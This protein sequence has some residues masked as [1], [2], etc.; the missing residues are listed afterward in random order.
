MATNQEKLSAGLELHD[1]NIG[2]RK[3]EIHY[4]PKLLP[5]PDDPLHML[6]LP[7]IRY[8]KYS[9]AERQPKRRLRRERRRQYLREQKCPASVENN[10]VV[11]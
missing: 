10:T 7:T 9:K 11:S 1:G 8:K 4:D 5:I 3:S 2:I 6:I